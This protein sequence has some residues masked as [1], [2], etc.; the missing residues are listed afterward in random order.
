MLLS[1]VVD[2]F[3]GKLKQRH[4]HRLLPGHKRALGAMQRCRTQASRQMLASCTDC[5]HSTLIPHSC[6]HRLCPH[7][8][9]FESQRW[10]ENQ[11]QRRVP[12]EYFLLTFTVPRELR[13]LAFAHQRVFYDALM[14]CAWQTINQFSENDKEL[15]GRTGAIAVL[16]THSRRLDFHPHVHLVVP[17][18][19]INVRDRHWRTRARSGY[20]FSTKALACVFRA[21]LLSSLRQNELSLPS[22]IPPQWVVDALSVGRGDK[23]ITYLGKYLYRGVVREKDIVS[24]DGENVTFRYTENTGQVRTR[25]MKG[26]DFLWQLIQHTLPKGFRRARNYGFLHPNSKNLIH[27]LQVVLLRTGLLGPQRKQTRPLITCSNCGA[28]MVLVA[29]GL[30]MMSMQNETEPVSM[31]GLRAM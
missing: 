6:G 13:S 23:A 11:Q 27:V 18:A 30:S 5:E 2:A 7:C 22:T 1:S 26:E 16:H 21:K 10:L 20:L 19:A 29:V 31:Q 9:H 4:S 8:Q 3:E 14:S 12:S 28:E 25:T 24:M 17:A 15:R